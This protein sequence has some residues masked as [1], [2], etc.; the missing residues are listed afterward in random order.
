MPELPRSLPGDRRDMESRAVAEQSD[1]VLA[2]TATE[3]SWVVEEVDR[4]LSALR[5]LLG[6]LSEEE[7]KRARKGIVERCMGILC[8]G[9]GGL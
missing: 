6:G 9:R 7:R 1:V 4:E 5:I 3:L 2:L 8:K